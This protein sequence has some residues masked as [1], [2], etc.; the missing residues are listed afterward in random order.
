MELGP[1]ELD[2]GLAQAARRGYAGALRSFAAALRAQS[3]VLGAQAL[4]LDAQASAVEMGEAMIPVAM[5][6]M[7]FTGGEAAAPD[8]EPEIEGLR[9][10]AV[11]SDGKHLVAADEDGQPLEDEELSEALRDWLDGFAERYRMSTFF[12]EEINRAAVEAWPMD[13]QAA[14]EVAARIRH[15]EEGARG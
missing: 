7:V 2:V 3:D 15:R 4:A 8:E 5:P 12:V 9:R 6:R 10:L 11:S 1:E 14:R 13:D